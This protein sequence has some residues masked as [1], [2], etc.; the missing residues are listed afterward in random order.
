MWSPQWVSEMLI[1]KPLSRECNAEMVVLLPW[2]WR[3]HDEDTGIRAPPH[4]THHWGLQTNMPKG[5][6]RA[7]GHN[8]LHKPCCENLESMFLNTDHFNQDGRAQH[9]SA[10][11]SVGIIIRSV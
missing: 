8:S 5:S 3:G 4:L 10:N 11:S 1:R 7:T 6:W 9:D 2:D